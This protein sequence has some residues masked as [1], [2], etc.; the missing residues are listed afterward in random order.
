MTYWISEKQVD[1]SNKDQNNANSPTS[2]SEVK[3]TNNRVYFYSYVEDKSILKF[4]EALDAATN[5]VLNYAVTN[6]T[7]PAPVYIHINSGGGSLFAGFA[8][9]DIIERCPAPTVSIVE[10]RAASAAT[11]MSVAANKR[12][13]TPHS[14]MLIHQ[15]SSGMWGTYE[16]FKDHRENIEREM[17]MIRNVY[18]EKTSLSKKMLNELLKRDLYF[19]PSKCIKMG[20]VDEIYR[21]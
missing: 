17:D 21:G 4:Q 11:L 16:N 14:F 15:L 2:S 12:V 9:M 5:R 19:P 1:D 7:E 8:A 20:L 13:I 3:G 10:G 18:L 6:H